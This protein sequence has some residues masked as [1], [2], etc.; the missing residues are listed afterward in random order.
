MKN[1]I[2]IIL[3]EAKKLVRPSDEERVRRLSI[4]NRIVKLLEE[5]FSR[6][7]INCEISI[8]GSLAK[9]TWLPEGKDIDIFL[10]FPKDFP[11]ERF[12]DIIK[13]LII[14]AQKSGIRWILKYAQHPYVQYIVDK[15]EIDI[16]P[17][18]RIEPGE[19]PL[20]AA[21]RTPLHTNYVLSKL[22]ENPDLRDDIRLFKRFLKVLGI[23]G[24][25]IKVEGFSG[26]L[27][28]LLIL[29]YGS[30]IN[31]IKDVAERWKP[32]HIIIDVEKHYSDVKTI[33]KLFK[34]SPIIVIDPVDPTRN[35]AAA[36]SVESLSK[37]I[38]ASKLF[39]HKPDILFF[40]YPEKYYV[41]SLEKRFFPPIVVIEFPYP[42]K[43][44]PETVWGEAKRLCRSIWNVLE[45][46]EYKPYDVSVW[47]DEEN[48]IVIL[49][50]VERDELTP[51][52]FHKGPPVYSNDVLKFL[53][54]YV[55]DEE[56]L[57]PYIMDSRVVVIKRRKYYNVEVLL[58]AQLPLIA[59][60]HFK[61]LVNNCKIVVLKSVDDIYRLYSDIRDVLLR[62]LLKREF[63]Y[64]NLLK[65]S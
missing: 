2:E 56:C 17:C 61:K 42:K 19:K 32:K 31:L 4:A 18:Y 60:K 24:A 63:W 5:E 22:S 52:E 26:Y 7:S 28:E 43:L 55:N 33:K 45:R 40:K 50:M 29:N 51:Y 14:V 48:R 62:F 1:S 27:A 46:Y 23:Y 58:K 38:L 41:D 6:D 34:D 49:I 10:I 44:V 3:E 11:K 57:G 53:S 21:D 59:P 54:K 9:D 36:V 25:E 47:S 16:V 30:F 64:V 37:L 15:Y 13:K 39:L 65:I 35:A 12:E 20:T 8:Q